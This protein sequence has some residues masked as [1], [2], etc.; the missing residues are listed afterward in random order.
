M[1]LGPLLNSARDHYHQP[2][3]HT[4]SPGKHRIA[5]NLVK[6]LPR[7]EWLGPTF[8]RS[9]RPT[10]RMN[11]VGVLHGAGFRAAS[12]PVS[13]SVAHHFDT[14][15]SHRPDR[16]S[17]IHNELLWVCTCV[18]GVGSRSP[19]AAMKLLYRGS[20]VVHPVIILCT[21]RGTV[22]GTP[23]GLAHR[24]SMTSFAWRMPAAW[25]R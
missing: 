8:I 23:V 14:N 13:Q 25:A 20:Q 22:A 7:R 16:N 6:H 15:G 1:N 21:L 18:P 11:C 5:T 9:S 12:Q 17:K 19:V 24:Q 3:D 10:F 4:H 2:I